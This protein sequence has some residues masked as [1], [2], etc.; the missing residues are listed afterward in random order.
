MTAVTRQQHN[1]EPVL[2]FDNV[3]VRY[4]KA[5]KLFHNP[6]HWALR[7]VSLQLFHGETLGVVGSN[8]SG[9]STLM[10]LMAGII[11]PDEGS[12]HRNVGSVQLLSLQVGFLNHLSGRENAIMS[13]MLLGLRKRDVLACMDSIIAFSELGAQ[14][15]DPVRTYSAGMRARL[16]FAVANHTHPDILLIDEAL[17]VGDARFRE[18]SKA[19]MADRINSD[20][21]IVLVSHNEETI[22]QFC[23]RVIWLEKGSIRA[24]GETGATVDAYLEAG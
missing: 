3:G 2:Q 22:R 15:D 5:L 8:G 20:K 7:H 10:K 18:K 24:T 14:I 16:G 11:N 13:G 17:G 19:V 6:A 4:K 23:D 21:T 1:P 9:K 12:I